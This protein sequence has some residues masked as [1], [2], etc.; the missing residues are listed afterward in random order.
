M[1]PLHVLGIVL[2]VVGLLAVVY[3][4][5]WFTKTEKKAEIGPVELRV[6]ERERVNV[7]LW[8]GAGVAVVGVGLLLSQRRR[9]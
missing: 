6:K 4:G 2:L 9:A 5:F 8:V 1:R 7:P 3:G